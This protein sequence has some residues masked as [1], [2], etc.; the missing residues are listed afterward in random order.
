MNSIIRTVLG[1]IS[2][3]KL[4]VTYMHEHL[5]IESEIV[6][7]DF[8]FIY[9][10][11]VVDAISEVL[12]C[13]NVGVESMVD[14]MPTGAGRNAE[15]LKKISESTGINIIA[16][17]GLHHDR[18]YK[19]DDAIERLDSEKLA[20]L[21]ISEIEK[22]MDDTDIK[23]GIIKVATSGPD[24]KYREI[25][26]FEAAAIATQKTGAPII[27]H[28]EHGTGALEQ[29]NLFQKLGVNLSK[30]TL[31][32]TDKE[33]DPGY[34]REILSSGI[35]LEYDQSLRQATEVKP[36]S[37]QLTVEMINAG[38]ASQIMLGTDGAR[39]SLW[40]CLGGS[41][42]LG[43]LYSGWSKKLEE[44]GVSEHQLN[45]L[46]ISNPASALTFSN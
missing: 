34:H 30:V 25:K 21:F 32:H 31:S 46:F 37:A 6:K 41:P 36:K 23:A 4:G 27:S 9:L 26:L 22:G 43:W 19:H 24:I 20:K 15:K 16:A 7:K 39:R 35:N 13:K 42:G 11:S 45:K 33:N 1:D 44:L 29:I 3:E 8:E 14:C 18:Y 10:P 5:I 40:S 12:L 17:T 38:F 2:P 28:C